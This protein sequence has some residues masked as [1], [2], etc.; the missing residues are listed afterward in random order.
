M[1]RLGVGRSRGLGL[2]LVYLAGGILGGAPAGAEHGAV[3]LLV[4]LTTGDEWGQVLPLAPAAQLVQWQGRMFV[5]VG[6]YPTAAEARRAGRRVQ[7]RLRLPFV[8]DAPPVE[9]PL[10]RQAEA[11]GGPLRLE[12]LRYRPAPGGLSLP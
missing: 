9:A 4:S 1:I 8:I 6:H 12:D 2:L 7:D 3:R 10:S 5:L 11:L